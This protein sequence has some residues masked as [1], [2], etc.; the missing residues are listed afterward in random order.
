MLDVFY[1]FKESYERGDDKLFDYDFIGLICAMN[2][3]D[4]KLS[5]HQKEGIGEKLFEKYESEVEEYN[6]YLSECEAES[7]A[8]DMAKDAYYNEKYGR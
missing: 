3:F 6:D 4:L 7:M 5:M 8:E 1:L 2:E